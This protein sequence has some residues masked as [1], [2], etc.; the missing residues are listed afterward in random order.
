MKNKYMYLDVKINK[1]KTDQ[2]TKEL[3]ENCLKEVQR[4]CT[5]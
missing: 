4:G 5:M 3:V 2:K 1:L